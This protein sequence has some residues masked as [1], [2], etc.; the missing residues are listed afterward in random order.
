MKTIVALERAMEDELSAVKRG[1]TIT[2]FM[3]S[4]RGGRQI[5]GRHIVVSAPGG[6]L[7]TDDKKCIVRI[8]RTYFSPGV[9]AYRTEYRK[10]LYA[11]TGRVE[12]IAEFRVAY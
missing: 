6:R 11:Y 12:N 1:T 9:K 8:L 3:S 2:R 10:Y 5:L 4:E 7:S